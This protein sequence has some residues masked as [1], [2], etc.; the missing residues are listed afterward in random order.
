MEYCGYAGNILRVDLGS[1]RISREPLD[2]DLASRFIGGPGVGLNLLLD[3]LEPNADPL[4]PENPLVFGTGPL[5]G[6]LVPGSAKGYLSTKYTMPAGADKNKCFVSSS[7]FG[8]RRFGSMMKNAGYDHIVITGRAEIPSYL[9]VTDEDVE[10]CDASDLW[11]R[12][13]YETSDIL[14]RRYPGKTG[15]CGVWAIGKAGEN[16]VRP[17]LGFADDLH[18]AGR[19]AGAVAGAKNFKAIVTLGAKGV[20]IADRKR[21][22][23]L[24][25]RKRN[26]ILEYPYEPWTFETA[27]CNKDCTGG[28]CAVKVI[29]EAK[30]GRFKGQ[31][32]GGSYIGEMLEWDDLS[33]WSERFKLMDV[34]NRQGLC[35]CT[36]RRMIWFLTKLYERGVISIKDTG[37]VELKRGDFDGY[38][39]LIEKML[40][41]EDIGAAMAEGW[42]ALCERVGVDASTDAEA[43]CSIIKGIDIILDA[44]FWLS[45]FSPAVGLAQI[46]H[47]KA[48][49][50]HSDTSWIRGPNPDL[51]KDCEEMGM[52]KQEIDRVLTDDS[53]NTGRLTVYTEDAETVYNALGQCASAA[54]LQGDPMRDVPWLAEVY[55]SVT[56]FDITP[57][58]LLRSGERIRNLERLLN[59]R[60]GFTREDDK[61]PALY[62]QNTETPVKVKDIAFYAPD[63]ND[64]YL[65]DW[66]GKR[67]M[68]DDLE[69]M[70]DDYYEER[71]WDPGN[72]VPTRE[73]LVQLGLENF[74]ETN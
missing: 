63:G 38:M 19:F 68:K 37:G 4:S 52:L 72:G 60:E 8:G 24:Y 32:F 47:A 40:N 1:G 43:G 51:R 33:D 53:F 35:M 56:G 50:V 6:T 55:S 69:Q 29:H 64:R 20:R 2:S 62:I 57:R 34:M 9:K 22:M 49:Q 5:M 65:M 61:I 59:V 44:R 66:Y 73:K 17:S 71:G 26:Q 48:K 12:D 14:R 41:K 23:E 28:M 58:E 7:M 46:V 13:I 39:A 70:L 25:T 27:V 42:Q 45:H 67:L 11:G 15:V 74:I 3:L 16:L 31:R 10:I 21:F 36:A 30:E 54:M 18:N